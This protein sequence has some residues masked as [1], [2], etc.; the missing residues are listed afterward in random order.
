MIPDYYKVLHGVPPY[1]T[2]HSIVKNAAN[3]FSPAWRAI[4]INT[5]NNFGLIL[6]AT[7]LPFLHSQQF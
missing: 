3:A 2:A 6:M 7:T 5:Y 4:A 1:D